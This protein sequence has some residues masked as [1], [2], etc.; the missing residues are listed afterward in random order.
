MRV[1]RFIAVMGLLLLM[2][3]AHAENGLFVLPF[4]GE[5]GAPLPHAYDYGKPP[6]QEGAYLIRVPSVTP[7]VATVFSDVELTIDA[8][9]KT[10]LHSRAKRAY[11]SLTECTAALN[12]V[13][14]KLRLALPDTYSG[15]NPQWQHQSADGTRVGG[16]YCHQERHLPF[17]ILTLE[18]TVAP[19]P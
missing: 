6:M 4:G 12:V 13:L 1:S 19:V 14:P 10:V 11:R 2:A 9:T 15:A 17:P 5:P 8:A 16:I 18:L 7:E 3:G